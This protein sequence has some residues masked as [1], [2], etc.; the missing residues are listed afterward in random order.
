M[1]IIERRALCKNE[2][3]EEEEEGEGSWKRKEGGR[4]TTKAI[5]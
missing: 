5:K 1:S 4:E 2:E 3:E